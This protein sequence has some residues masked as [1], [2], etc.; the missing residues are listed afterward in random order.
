MSDLQPGPEVPGTSHLSD[1]L[2]RYVSL[3]VRQYAEK[4]L[5]DLRKSGPTTD[6]PILDTDMLE[7]DCLA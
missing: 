4:R 2:C 3:L 7:E 6:S 1:D 5:G